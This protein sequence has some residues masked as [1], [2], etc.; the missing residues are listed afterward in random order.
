MLRTFAEGRLF[1][2]SSGGTSA[3]GGPPWALAL[4]GWGRT[5]RDFDQLLAAIGAIA[6]DLPG[7]GAAPAPPAPWS[8]ADYAAAV[9]SLLDEFASPPVIVGHSFGG[10]VAVQLAAAC[11][12]R[13][14]GLVL[15][16]VPLVADPAKVAR[17]PAMRFRLGRRLHRAGV[18]SEARMEALR[19]RYGSEDYRQSSGAMRGVLV[20]AVNETYGPSLAAFPGPIELVWGVHD[21]QVPLRVA[22][23]ALSS[24]A[25]GRL[26]GV[27]GVG[28]FLPLEAPEALVEA[29]GR[30]RPPAT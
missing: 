29:A 4:P 6:V 24:C 21:D 17:P 28:H 10:R 30:L 5:H 8:T 20:K 1:G 14:A 23:A 22:E 19:Q 25:D 27:A 7:F 12:D 16:G 2:A 13:I 9:A 26:H 11:P 3:G 15:T 18:L